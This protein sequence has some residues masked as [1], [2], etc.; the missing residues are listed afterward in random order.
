MP[1]ALPRRP[2]R[3][4]ADIPSARGGRA[5]AIRARGESRAESRPPPR[6]TR[7]DRSTARR[8][9]HPRA[10]R[11]QA[12]RRAA[13]R[14]RVGFA[15][16]LDVRTP[17]GGRRDRATDQADERDEREDVRH[18]RDEVF[19]DAG[20]PLQRDGEREPEAEEEAR[21]EGPSWTPLAEDNCRERDEP[22]SAR[23]VLGEAADEPDRQKGASER[24]K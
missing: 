19:R 24:C 3:P 12:A 23:H 5:R 21:G 7:R 20:L 11:V 18:G 1:P 2:A 9:L 22:A 17:D 6:R 16:L 14:S 4:C 15:L 8:S 10:L 13:P